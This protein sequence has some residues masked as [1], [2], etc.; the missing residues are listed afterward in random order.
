MVVAL[1]CA[2]GP[3]CL[4]RL[5]S[6]GSF[7]PG[8][9][10]GRMRVECVEEVEAEDCAIPLLG[11]AFQEEDGTEWVAMAA[12]WPGI[13]LNPDA[14]PGVDT[15]AAP[16]ETDPTRRRWQGSLI[17]L[18]RFGAHFSRHRAE[19]ADAYW[20][21]ETARMLAIFRQSSTLAPVD[22]WAD[23]IRLFIEPGLPPSR[24]NEAAMRR[25][26]VASQSPGITDTKRP[27]RPRGSRRPRAATVSA[28]PPLWAWLGA[29]ALFPVGLCVGGGFLSFPAAFL[30][31]VV[32]GT[33][34][35][36]LLR[37]IGTLA[38]GADGWFAY[39][40]ATWTSAFCLSAA[41]LMATVFARTR[42]FR[43]RYLVFAGVLG[44]SI[45]CLGSVFGGADPAS[46]F[47]DTIA[48]ASIGEPVTSLDLRVDDY[49][50]YVPTFLAGQ[51]GRVYV[52]EC[53]NKVSDLEFVAAFSTGPLPGFDG[54]P[55]IVPEPA[56]ASAAMYEAVSAM[57][58]KDGWTSFSP[59]SGKDS[60]GS[61]REF[62]N[63][64]RVR[65]LANDCREFGRTKLCSVS[66]RTVNRVPCNR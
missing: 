62:R 31:L 59:R 25:Q 13:I 12:P 48:P 3:P 50:R 54:D 41:F 28:A 22:T 8:L 16:A 47:T 15:L 44:P 55:I 19:L 66:L 21:D 40:A 46:Y 5:A 36:N 32:T 64:R 27:E 52:T 29:V 38:P 65:G 58:V 17:A 30:W 6:S 39:S 35:D 2:L 7:G 63:G 1:T 9:G 37:D 56:S 34:S 20:S 57:V 18:H 10:G 61:F 26:V 53:R 51:P 4:L 42:Q 43:L 49:G 14:V 23:L 45:A 33:Y 24:V 60:A 11:L